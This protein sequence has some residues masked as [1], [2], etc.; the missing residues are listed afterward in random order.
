MREAFLYE[1]CDNGSV[2]CKLCA[3]RCH[4][5]LNKTGFCGVRTNDNG[6]L[7]TT[8]Y[9]NLAASAIDPIEKKPLYHFLPGSTTYSI[10]IPGCN[11]RC[12][13]CQ[14]WEISQNNKMHLRQ[15]AAQI[16]PSAV[17]KAALANKCDSISFTYTEPTIFMEYAFETARLAR[18]KGLR[19]VFVSNGYMTTEALDLMAPFLDACN[20]D[21]KA[22]TDTFYKKYVK[23]IFSR[24]SIPL[25][26]ST[27]KG[28]ISRSPHLSSRGKTIHPKNWGK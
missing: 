2:K 28:F 26:K 3:H 8:A 18:E 15:R 21:L 22:F 23:R 14:N 10:A 16:E 12:G 24:C 9:G 1:Q 13:F 17:V 5:S 7:Y 25:S 27:K 20:I 11:F 6:V 19:T 4:I